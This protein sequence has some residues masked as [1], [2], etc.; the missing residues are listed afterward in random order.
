MM[1]NTMAK[2][3]VLGSGTGSLDSQAT[4]PVLDPETL[5]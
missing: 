5:L 3:S 4:D 2:G 1:F